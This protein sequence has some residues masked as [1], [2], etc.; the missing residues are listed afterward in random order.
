MSV[1]LRQALEGAGYDLTSVQDARWLVQKQQEF[2]TLV[3][4]AELTIEEWENEHESE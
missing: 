3:E 2:E 1:S 4:E